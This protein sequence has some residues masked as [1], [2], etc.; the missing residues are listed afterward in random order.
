[1]SGGRD[2]IL[3][4]FRYLRARRAWTIRICSRASRERILR[5]EENVAVSRDEMEFELRFRD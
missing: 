2:V 3:L 5:R 1:M 4:E